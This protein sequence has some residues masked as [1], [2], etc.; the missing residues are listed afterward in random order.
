MN[1]TVCA[2]YYLDVLEFVELFYNNFVG[3]EKSPVQRSKQFSGARIRPRKIEEEK[4]WKILEKKQEK[5]K[6]KI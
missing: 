4:N 5:T 6:S 1:T 2:Q 3:Q